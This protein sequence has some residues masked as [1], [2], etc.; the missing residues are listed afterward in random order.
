[1]GGTEQVVVLG[2]GRS[3][4][5]VEHRAY[6]S[7]GLAGRRG[8]GVHRAV[9]GYGDHGYVLG[10]G[11]EWLVVVWCGE[12]PGFISGAGGVPA[13]PGSR[14]GVDVAVSRFGVDGVASGGLC[15]S[16]PCV[17]CTAAVWGDC[18]FSASFVV[19]WVCGVR[20]GVDISVL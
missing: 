12:S 15:S 16:G 8:C 17:S 11:L 6:A 20:A 3:G 5:L 13:A 19:E 14:P 9:L 7:G 1:M 18:Y 4:N 10:V 2:T